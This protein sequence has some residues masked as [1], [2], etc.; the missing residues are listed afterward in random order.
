MN[1]VKFMFNRIKDHTLIYETTIVNDEISDISYYEEKDH[2]KT[3]CQKIITEVSQRM[4]PIPS[5]N[6]LGCLERFANEVYVLEN[7]SGKYTI[8]MTIDTFCKN[9]TRLTVDII[10][11]YAI[12]DIDKRID[13]YLEK[14]KL[15]LKNRI[16]SDWSSCTWL[17]DEQSEQMCAELYPEF[18]RLENEIRAFVAKVLT[19]KIG[20]NW[21]DRFGLEKFCKS[22]KNLSTVFQQRVPEFNNVNADLISLTLEA[23]FEIVFNGTIYKD[24]TILTPSD[25]VRLNNIIKAGIIDNVKVFLDKKRTIQ[26]KIWDDIF[27]PYFVDAIRFKNNLTKFINSR[28]HIAHNKLISFNAYAIICN[29]L[30]LFEE[31]LDLAKE[32]FEKD[33]LS[34]EMEYTLDALSCHEANEYDE[35]AFWRTRV[36]D[37]TGI[38]ILDEEQIYEK[39]IESLDNVRSSLIK[40]LQYDPCFTIEDISNTYIDN[41][42]VIFRIICNAD[43][44][45]FIEIRAMMIIDD[46]M[47]EESYLH[48]YCC[49]NEDILYEATVTY[50]NG[51]GNEDDELRIQVK[52]DSEYHDEG[53]EEFTT[54]VIGYIE[55]ELNPFI[56]QIENNAHT[57]KHNESKVAEFSCDVCGRN[58]VSINDNFYPI[59]SCCFCGAEHNIV[60]CSTCGQLFKKS[61][62]DDTNCNECLSK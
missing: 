62:K 14:L 20:V 40:Y 16:I 18:F 46:D 22:A 57:S 60:T 27:I 1:H 2:I 53:I 26:Y 8:S 49:K 56:C 3:Y 37:E 7:K 48:I 51:D 6:Y 44:N 13:V 58:G 21:I 59:G 10:P 23:L 43:K 15:E 11:E 31:D 19:Y 34:K 39:F 4:Q 42:T 54:N 52:H 35:R 36:S 45:S 5:V 30:E 32:K 41:E 12:N 61:S 33:V 38:D 25:Y 29:E 28:N 55:N 24:E 47:G 9:T 17:I 50:I